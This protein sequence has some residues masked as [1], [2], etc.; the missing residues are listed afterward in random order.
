M[1]E[2]LHVKRRGRPRKYSEDLSSNNKR[3]YHSNDTF[4][5]WRAIWEIHKLSSDDATASYLLESLEQSLQVM[6]PSLRNGTFA[7][8]A[9]WVWKLHVLP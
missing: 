1:A 7:I 9:R 4:L 5:K 6:S 3:I 2:G 8:S